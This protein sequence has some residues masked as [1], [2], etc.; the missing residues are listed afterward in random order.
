MQSA[1]IITHEFILFELFP[2]E[3]CHE[4]VSYL[5]LGTCSRYLQETSYKYET[6]LDDVQRAKTVTLAFLLFE[7]FPLELCPSQKTCPLFNL[8]TVQDIF[9]KLYEYQSTLDNMQSAR[10]I[11]VA[12]ILFEISLGI[13]LVNINVCWMYNII[14]HQKGG[15]H[16]CFC[17]KKKKKKKF[18]SWICFYIA[19]YNSLLTVPR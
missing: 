10:T 4:M 12:F 7:L 13:S 16:P 17:K 9:M 2:L 19:T 11:T 3:L 5:K 6:T 18:F 1:R 14:W 15:R 8:K